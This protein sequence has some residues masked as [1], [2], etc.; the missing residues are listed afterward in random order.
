MMKSEFDEA[1]SRNP[2]VGETRESGANDEGLAG[3]YL[4]II[5]KQM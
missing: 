4:N 5:N 2:D 3:V 1:K